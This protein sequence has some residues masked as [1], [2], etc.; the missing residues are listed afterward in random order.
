[1]TVY[2]HV[3]IPISLTFRVV[4]YCWITNSLGCACQAPCFPPPPFFSSIILFLCSMLVSRLR[5]CKSSLSGF[6]RALHILSFFSFPAFCRLFPVFISCASLAGHLRQGWGLS[7]C[8]L[9]Y[10]VLMSGCWRALYFLLGPRTSAYGDRRSG[11]KAYRLLN[12]VWESNLTEPLLDSQV[13]S[14]PL[15]Y[16]GRDSADVPSSSSQVEQL[17]PAGRILHINQR[18]RCRWVA[19]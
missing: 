10:R 8:F 13:N 12:P 16:I 19:C 1:M 11:S 7:F 9:Q 15:S 18:M 17:F 14:D 6:W 4:K 2:I 3:T 5:A